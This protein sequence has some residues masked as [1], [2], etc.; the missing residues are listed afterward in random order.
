MF[1][2]LVLGGLA[3]VASQEACGTTTGPAGDG[4]SDATQGADSFPSELPVQMEAGPNPNDAASEA[5]ADA[6]S[7]AP[8]GSDAFPSELPSP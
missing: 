5:A 6:A 4:G 8:L 2:V 1:R 7:D 3:L